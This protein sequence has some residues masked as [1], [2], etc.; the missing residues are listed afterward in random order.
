ML[1]RIRE[2]LRSDERGQALVLF[3]G[4][5]VAF[6]A[7]VGLSIDVGRYV[8]A[9]TQIQAAVDS[10]ALAAAQSMPNGT[11]EAGDYAR[12]YWQNNNDFIERHAENVN[13]AVTFPDGNRAVKVEATADIPTW[14][15]RLVGLESWR[16]GASGRAEAQVLDIAVVLD[17]SGSMCYDTFIQAE[18][19]QNVLMSP[20][21]DGRLPRLT[22][23]IAPGGGSTIDIKLDSVAIFNSTSSS[24]NNANFGYSSS[25]R[26][27][28]RTIS[29]R[30]GIIAIHSGLNGSGSYE[31]FKINS[32][33]SARKTLNVTR[34]QRNN[35][36]GGSTSKMAHPAGAEVWAN[37]VGCDRA[38]RAA[39]DGP[40]LPYD[41]AMSAATYFTTLFNPAYDK[42]G[43]A[44]F[45]TRAA[46]NLGLSSNFGTVRN[47]IAGLDF[48]EGNTN[49]AHGLAQGRNIV[50]GP[51]KR[52]NAVRVIVLLT[53]GIA[54]QYCGSSSYSWS[55]Y[56][57]S[58]SSNANNVSRAVSHAELV[59]N[60]IG[61]DDTLIYTIG[62][63][64][65]VD[66]DFLRDIARR[67]G[68]S[69]YFS[70]T[71]AELDAAFRAIADET[72]IALTQ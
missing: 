23:A 11:S 54:N 35:F 68:G 38:A 56:S 22:E 13:F 50:N 14:F 69:Y 33:D 30:S 25:D 43:V 64:Y 7:L 32:I 10:A 61:G 1:N 17:I 34:A 65:D 29:G 48:P 60:A 40:F 2:L 9:R 15:L 66:G 70:P 63:G 4:G 31:L 57:G 20:G 27:Y 58:C 53:D 26:Y 12:Q 46:A 6:L 21:L 59:A 55:S 49:I 72:H 16:V 36:T 39:S 28:S 44:Q 71:T 41:P 37:R 62:L 51:G 8:W 19:A 42:I 3:A 18:S 45:S 24:T 67:G 52:P 47:A 5:L